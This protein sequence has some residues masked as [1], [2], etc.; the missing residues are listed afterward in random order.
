MHIIIVHNTAKISAISVYSSSYS[1]QVRARCSDDR[2]ISCIKK[3]RAPA[4]P[5]FSSDRS[6]VCAAC[7]NWKFTAGR[8]CCLL[9]WSTR[10]ARGCYMSTERPLTPIVTDWVDAGSYSRPVDKQTDSEST[11]SSRVTCVG[12]INGHNPCS[13]SWLLGLID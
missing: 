5:L 9:L 3:S 1:Q 7:N 13:T 8:R 6:S 10:S 11:P 4:T 2:S 12:G